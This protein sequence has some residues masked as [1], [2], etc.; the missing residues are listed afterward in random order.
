MERDPSQPTTD[1]TQ[2][3]NE[4]PPPFEP[5]PRLFAHLER[6]GKPSTE[7]DP[8]NHR[9]SRERAGLVLVNHRVVRWVETEMVGHR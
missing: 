8:G 3:P 4:S 6:G 5:D 2:P 7:E 9:S 1:E